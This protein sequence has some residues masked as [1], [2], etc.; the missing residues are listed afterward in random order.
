MNGG[1][2]GIQ[3]WTN[4]YHNT[5]RVLCFLIQSPNFQAKIKLSRSDYYYDELEK[6]KILTSEG[7]IITLHINELRNNSVIV[8]D[9]DYKNLTDINWLREQRKE[10]GLIEGKIKGP[11]FR[12]KQQARR[13]KRRAYRNQQAIKFK[14]QKPEELPLSECIFSDD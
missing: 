4:K 9:E 7:L 2:P 11:E 12:A 8:P 6:L 13:K 5:L 14:D 1:Y 3:T 10:L